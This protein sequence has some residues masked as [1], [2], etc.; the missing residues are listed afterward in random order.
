[1]DRRQ[2]SKRR[3][4][5][6]CYP[7]ALIWRI[8]PPPTDYARHMDSAPTWAALRITPG[9]DSA[10][11]WAALQITPGMDSEP[12]W[13]ALRT[14][15]ASSFLVLPSKLS[16]FLGISHTFVGLLH[17]TWEGISGVTLRVP[18]PGCPVQRSSS[19]WSLPY[20]PPYTS[21]L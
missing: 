8:A 5:G 7:S 10:P 14:V 18:S 20:Q 17:R 15:P 12:T 9:M 11:T 19:L 16:T 1:M 6:K 21:R 2:T 4:L 13:D 3:S